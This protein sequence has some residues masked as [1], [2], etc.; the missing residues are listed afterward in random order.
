MLPQDRAARNV[1]GDEQ[2]RN[3]GCNRLESTDHENR[4]SR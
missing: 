3:K 2:I 1:D 4:P